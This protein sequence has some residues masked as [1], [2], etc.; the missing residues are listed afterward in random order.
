MCGYVAFSI[1]YR[2]FNVHGSFGVQLSESES[3]FR[4][5]ALFIPKVAR[6]N[7]N[8]AGRFSPSILSF[9]KQVYQLSYLMCL[10]RQLTQHPGVESLTL[11]KLAL[12]RT[13]FFASRGKSNA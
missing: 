7:R 8:K 12:T 13:G 10:V 11:A 1:I 4:D 6:S 9:Q 2:C 3:C 5:I